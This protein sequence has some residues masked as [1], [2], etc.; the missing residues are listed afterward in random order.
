MNIRRAV[1]EDLTYLLFL[2]IREYRETRAAEVG[3][4]MSHADIMLKFI[5]LMR[6]PEFGTLLVAENDDKQ[7]VGYIYGQ[8]HKGWHGYDT[9]VFWEEVG[10]YVKKDHRGKGI[11]LA[12]FRAAEQE[13]RAAGVASHMILTTAVGSDHDKLLKKY[14]SDGFTPL[15]IT[16]VKKITED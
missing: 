16:C 14:E 11:G 1:D 8:Y 15:Q 12:L 4:V 6:Q 9:F 3:I 10:W 5:V 2:F 13:V 7:V